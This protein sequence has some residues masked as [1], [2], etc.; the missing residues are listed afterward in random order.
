MHRDY[1]RQMVEALL[2]AHYNHGVL[3]DDTAPDPTMP[4]AASNKARQ[5]GLV[6]ALID[7]DR[8]LER[9][10]LTPRER[11]GIYLRY[12]H[13]CNNVEIAKGLDVSEWTIRTDLARAVSA[14]E[15]T[16]NGEPQLEEEAS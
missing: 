13:G 1:E 11:D 6:V 14:I 3:V 16:I 9:T 10:P 12:C 7:I 2:V 4:K 8:A 15:R 5:G